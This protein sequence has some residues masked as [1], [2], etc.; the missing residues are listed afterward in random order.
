MKIGFWS[1]NPERSGITKRS[2]KECESRLRS[3]IEAKSQARG[4][5]NA[6]QLKKTVLKQ[7]L[8]DEKELH[9]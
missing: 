6:T 7:R 5:C 2:L 4:A 8:A 3:K 1:L 9:M